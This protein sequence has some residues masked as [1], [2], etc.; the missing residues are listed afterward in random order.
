[1]DVKW[2]GTG[3][4]SKYNGINW[5]NYHPL[6]S[7]IPLGA[8]LS[9]TSRNNELWVSSFNKGIG[10]LIDTTWTRFNQSNSPLPDDDT[11]IISRDNENKIWIG[12]ETGGIAVISEENE[13]EFINSSNSG[14]PSNSITELLL[15]P[16]VKWVGTLVHGAG[17]LIDTTWT[18]YNNQNSPIPS[19]TISGLALDSNGNT[20][21]GTPGGLAVFNEKGI[22]SVSNISN[23]IPKDF[24]LHQNYPNPF[25]PTTVIKYYISKKSNIEI[26]VFNI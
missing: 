11:R 18:I 24:I 8:I 7:N 3:G 13:W 2:F 15:T 22:V 5:T 9:V 20:W 25:N 6:N 26:I 19:F 16:N 4:V 12:M 17:R 23:E 1:M 21:I 14:I 10:R